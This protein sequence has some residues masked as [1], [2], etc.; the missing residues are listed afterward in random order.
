MTDSPNLM[1]TKVSPL[2]GMLNLNLKKNYLLLGLYEGLEQLLCFSTTRL[3]QTAMNDPSIAI[4]TTAPS[5]SITCTIIATRNDGSHVHAHI[6]AVHGAVRKEGEDT[7]S[8][9]V[10]WVEGGSSEVKATI[11]QHQ[12]TLVGSHLSGNAII[13]MTL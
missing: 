6:I 13:Y 4:S 11:H 12:R 8:E 10:S 3:S 2:Y 5:I 1:L 7:V 9:G